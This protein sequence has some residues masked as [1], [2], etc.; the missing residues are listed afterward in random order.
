[1][2]S[3]DGR[4]EKNALILIKRKQ[5]SLI[6]LWIGEARARTPAE[7]GGWVYAIAVAIPA[8]DIAAVALSAVAKFRVGPGALT[9]LAD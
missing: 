1:L 9:G 5:L 3:S 7:E 4:K 8:F 6:G 2:G